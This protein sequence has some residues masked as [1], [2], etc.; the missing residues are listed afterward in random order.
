MTAPAPREAERRTETVALPVTGMT[1]AACAR[2]IARTLDDTPGV[3]AADVNFATGRATVVFDPALVTVGELAGAVRDVGYDVLEPQST[4]QQVDRSTDRSQPQSEVEIEDRLARVQEAEYRVLRR[5]FIVAVA[6][7]VPLVVVAMAHVHF[8]GV[9]WV[10]LAL[11]LPVVAY[12]GAHFYRGA[13]K[14]LRHRAADMNTLIAVGTG[15]AFA[16]SLAGHRRARAHRRPGRRARRPGA[17]GWMRAPGTEVYFEVAAAIIALVLLGRAA[18]IAARGAARR[19]P[20]SGSSTSSRAPPAW[21]ATASEIGR[22]RGRRAARRHRSSSGPASGLRWTAR[23][24]MGRRPW[25]S[26]CSPA[27][28]CPVDKAAGRDGVRREREH[29]RQ[30]PLHRDARRPRNHAPAHHPARAGGAGQP[31]ADRAPGRRHLRLLH[32][33]RHQPRHPDLRHLVRPAAGRPTLHARARQLR[34]RDDHRLPVR[35][36]P[37]HADGH[38]RR[39][40]HRAPRRAS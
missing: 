14:S 36:G 29:D 30:L 21:S 6:F 4:N 19:T 22:P 7:S 28:R 32:A 39:H 11:A 23:W 17:R 16:Y 5:K 8:A 18:R 34:G 15:V 33:G 12:S 3:E 1:C 20:S 38:P 9:N 25:T 37:R 2:T 26:R 40:R 35:D 27:S 31:R 10:Q 13:W 24:W